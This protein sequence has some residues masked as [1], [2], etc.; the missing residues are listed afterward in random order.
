LLPLTTPLGLGGAVAISVVLGFVAVRWLHAAVTGRFS[1][2]MIRVLDA[3]DQGT[4]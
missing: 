3:P 1:S 2:R 4:L